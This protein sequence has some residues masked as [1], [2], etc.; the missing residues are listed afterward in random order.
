MATGQKRVG[1]KPLVVI[2]KVRITHKV[3]LTNMEKHVCLCVLVSECITLHSLELMC[4]Y[5]DAQLQHQLWSA[6]QKGGQ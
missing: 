5:N 3:N 1:D 4:L 6:L 2:V